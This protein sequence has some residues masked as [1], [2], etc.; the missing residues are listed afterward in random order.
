MC[1]VTLCL[2]VYV[3][4]SWH[5]LGSAGTCRCLKILPDGRIVCSEPTIICYFLSLHL[6]LVTRRPPSAPTYSSSPLI[7]ESSNKNV[8]LAKRGRERLETRPLECLE[9]YVPLISSQ[10][11]SH[12]RH[13]LLFKRQQQKTPPGGTSADP[14]AK[15]WRPST[16]R[17][18]TPAG[19]ST[20]Q[21]DVRSEWSLASSG[22]TNSGNCG[23]P[24]V[25]N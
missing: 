10:S 1:T 23:T 2:C 21:Q 5:Q 11:V 18:R 12:A 8:N 7:R 16:T 9:I 24:L 25:S 19:G 22:G 15:G 20:M 17:A 14:S 6:Q 4:T 13:R 3:D